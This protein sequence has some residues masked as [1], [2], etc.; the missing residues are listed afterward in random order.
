MHNTATLTYQVRYWNNLYQ[1]RYWNN[2]YQVR[3]W[4]NLYQVRYWNNLYQVRYWN[5]LYQ[6]C[7]LINNLLLVKTNITIFFIHSVVGASA[8]TWF[9][10]YT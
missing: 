9:I 2:L 1:V 8:L 5:N 10:R 3:Y 6:V 7:L 4:N